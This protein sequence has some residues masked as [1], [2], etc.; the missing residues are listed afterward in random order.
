VSRLHHLTPA[1]RLTDV[2]P[3]FVVLS[4]SLCPVARESRVCVSRA[5]PRFRDLDSR[6]PDN[7][8]EPVFRPR[9]G[10]VFRLLLRPCERSY[11][12]DRDHVEITEGQTMGENGSGETQKEE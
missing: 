9:S 6:L 8:P 3:I 7:A 2:D 10:S 5:T 4:K 12:A 11:A 1:A